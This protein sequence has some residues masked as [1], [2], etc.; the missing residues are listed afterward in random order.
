MRTNFQLAT[1]TF[2][3]AICAAAFPSSAS[4]EANA[5]S[6]TLAN[7]QSK[8]KDRPDTEHS[9]DGLFPNLD[10]EMLIRALA[11]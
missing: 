8:E 1:A 5:T 2:A 11:K 3:N 4:S 7:R 6:T 10:Q 9:M